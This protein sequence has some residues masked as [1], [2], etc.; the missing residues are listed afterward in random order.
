MEELFVCESELLTFKA[1]HPEYNHFEEQKDKFG[2][3]VGYSASVVKE[4]NN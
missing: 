2:E 1:R 3:L 4:N